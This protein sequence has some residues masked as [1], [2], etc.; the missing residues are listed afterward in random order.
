MAKKT[1]VATRSHV[2]SKT[3]AAQ[4]A[5]RIQAR[6]GSP[7]ERDLYFN[8]DLP[9]RAWPSPQ[10][11]ANPSPLDDLIF[12]GGTTVPQMGFRNIYLGSQSNWSSSDIT[13]IDSAI[14]RA[15]QDLRLNAIMAQY[16]PGASLSCDAL[17]SLVLTDA[18]PAQLDEPAVQAKVVALFNAGQLGQQD[19]GATIFNLLL[20]PGTVLNLGTASSPNGLGG[21]HG[22]VH[23]QQNGKHITLYYSASVY[24]QMMPDGSQNGIV[25]FDQSWKNVVATLYHEL[26]EF[27]TDA[28]VNDAITQSNNDLLGWMSRQGRECGDQPI[29]VATSLAQVFQE[30]VASDGGSKI[31]VQFMYSNRVH[32]A[33]GPSDAPANAAA[34]AAAAL[35]SPPPGR[36]PYSPPSSLAIDRVITQSLSQLR[37]P[38]VLSVRPGYQMAGGWLTKKPA[39]VVTV[40]RKTD[41]LAPEDRLPETISG[42]AVDVRQAGPLQRLRASNPQLYA[43]VAAQAPP[44]LQLPRFA[45]ERDLQGNG[46]ASLDD[47]MAAARQ[48]A[49]PQLDYAPPPNAPLQPIVDDF[50]ITCHASPDAGWTQLKPFLQGVKSRLTVGM[51]DFTSAHILDT[52]QTAM[53][54]RKNLNLVLDHPAPDRTLD[55][56]DEETHDALQGALAARLKFAWALEAHDPKIDAWIYPSAYHIKVAVRDGT[57]FWL[58][59]GN[60]N[61]SNQPD[62]D[63]VTDLAGAGATLKSS[64]RDWHAIVEH[65]ALAGLFEKYLQND[66]SV[67]LQHQAGSSPSAAA[68]DA[69]GSLALPDMVVASRTPVQFFAPKTITARMKI[70]PVLTPDNYA[71]VILQLIN[72][73]AEKLYVQVPYITP[74]DK[75]EGLVLQGLIEAIAAK[76][77]AGLD[78]RV[79]MSSFEKAGALEQLQAAGI[80]SSLVKIQNNLHN[81][82]IIVDSSVVAVGSQNW[83]APGVTTNRDATLVIFN[84]AAAQYWESI[85][86]HDWMN[87]AVQH[88]AD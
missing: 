61:N 52:V 31:P 1:K 83:S 57:A 28:D 17:S 55:Q 40:D 87:M 6:P 25:A 59:S 68:L 2:S 81:K 53:R 70:Q 16:F 10:E 76:I 21:Y 66:L 4:Y 24:S 73:A 62:I 36:G 65:A 74:T 37:K 49:K 23:T 67:A 77:R 7:V 20:P 12:H 11:I 35:P 13:F 48:S 56:S 54:A 44:E 75:P 88:I 5:M 71:N 32:G 78:V 45:L 79:I 50:T 22:S 69:L 26:N 63:P 51:Y 27:R 47:S 85:F 34:Q 72:S 29:A 43:A 60:W 8:S 84:E 33:E 41:D 86:I 38:G 58:S 15:M 19:T 82:G 14:K 80:D 64:D 18:K 9:G 46:F 39:I 42:Y 30:V 3:S